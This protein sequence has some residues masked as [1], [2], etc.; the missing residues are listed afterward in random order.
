MT[1]Q[2]DIMAPESAV[3]EALAAA[4]PRVQ[5]KRFTFDTVFGGDG[6]VIAQAPRPRRL[7]PAEEVE[8]IRAQA[9]AD[10][11]QSVTALAEQAAAAALGRIAVDVGGALSTLA[12]VAHEHRAGS[13]A[14]AMAAA[15]KIAAEALALFPEAPA[16]AA[17]QALAREVEAYPRLVVH[18]PADLVDRFQTA[19]S[20]AADACGYP[21]QITVKASDAMSGAAFIFDWGDGRA[22]FDPEAAAARVVD[23]L[24]TALAAEGL[25]AEPLLPANSAPEEGLHHG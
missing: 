10:G 16:A 7:I 18:A 3:P 5:H 4:A 17:L 12:A 15:G 22:A 9:Y 11:Q 21:G 19:L 8:A 25:H 20:K 13:A 2:P 1:D 24:Q 6:D 23:A 14:L